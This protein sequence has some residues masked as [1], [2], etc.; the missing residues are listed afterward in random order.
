MNLKINHLLLSPHQSIFDALQVLNQAG[1]GVVLVVDSANRLIGVITDG[2]IRRAML[3]GHDLKT[4]IVDVMN[5][6]FVSALSGIPQH[7]AVALMRRKGLKHL[8]IHD[9]DQ[10]LCDLYCLDHLLQPHS[11]ENAVVIM[12]GGKGTR[13]LPHTLHCPKP[14]LPVGGKPMLEILIEQCLSLGFGKIFISV[15]YLKDQIITE[16]YEDIIYQQTV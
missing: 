14:M 12:A 5:T 9:Q 2:D 3:S 13:L 8:P 15:N 11:L 16:L 6:H 7:Q 4:P 10:V 1:E